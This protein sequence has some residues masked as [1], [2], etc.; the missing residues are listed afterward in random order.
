M[1][2]SDKRIG[3]T[4][5][6]LK[7]Y[8]YKRNYPPKLGVQPQP[9]I[10]K[11]DVSLHKYATDY[12]LWRDVINGYLEYIMENLMNGL[13]WRLNFHLGEINIKKI[14]G[15]FLV[16]RKAMQDTD[17]TKKFKKRVM[18]PDGY[19]LAPRW[20]RKSIHVKLKYNWIVHIS[21]SRLVECYRRVREDYTYIYKFQDA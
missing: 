4:E 18:N 21:K 20:Y 17:G 3:L 5:I 9:Y 13:P 12:H 6:Y 14:K 2:A 19:Y 7:G 11:E 15:S 16:D 8:K 1:R 10:K